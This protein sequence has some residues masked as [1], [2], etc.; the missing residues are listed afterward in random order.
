M[1]WQ[2][3]EPQDNTKIRNL[4]TVIRP[5]FSAI[6]EGDLTFKPKAINLNN[7]T[8]SGPSN[9]PSAIPDSFVLYSKEDSN[10]LPG[11][12]GIDENS[13]ITQFTSTPATIGTEGTVFLPGGVIMK[14]G[15]A[16]VTI[17]GTVVTYPVAF[18][19]NTLNVQLTCT[20]NAYGRVTTLTSTSF[21]AATSSSG[22]SPRTYY[23]VAIG[24]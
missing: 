2:V 18:P 15:T 3:G 5:N 4:G 11:L 14:W 8:V 24:Y 7:R 20:G 1:A 16:S 9:D 23:Y 17:G 19:T 6:Q 12:F 13:V 10:G 21:T 22:G